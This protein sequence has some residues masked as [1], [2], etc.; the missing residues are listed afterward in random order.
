MLK[1]KTND[2]VFISRVV[3]KILVVM[4]EYMLTLYFYIIHVLH[5][6]STF[7]TTL[8]LYFKLS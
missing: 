4:D 3:V 2:D 8:I 7:T 6:Y 5:I 1:K